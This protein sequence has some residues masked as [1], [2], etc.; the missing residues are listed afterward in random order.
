MLPAVGRPDASVR[1]PRAMIGRARAAAGQASRARAETVMVATTL[2]TPS[3]CPSAGPF[4]RTS[5]AGQHLLAL[6]RAHRG[7]VA[8]ALAPLLLHAVERPHA[9]AHAGQEGGAEG[10]RLGH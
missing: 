3:A 10:S 4:H 6:R 9:G 5:P 7:L 8:R 2:L 1:V